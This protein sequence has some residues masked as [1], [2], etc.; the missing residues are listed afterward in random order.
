MLHNDNTWERE[1]GEGINWT[2]Q[3]E[4][5]GVREQK[6]INAVFLSSIAKT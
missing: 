6:Q 3:H 4:I 2:D 5:E 1:R